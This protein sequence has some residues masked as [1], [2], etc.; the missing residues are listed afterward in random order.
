MRFLTDRSISCPSK[1]LRIRSKNA[2]NIALGAK[3]CVKTKTRGIGVSSYL[4]ARNCRFCIDPFRYS[5]KNYCH[6]RKKKNRKCW[7][8]VYKTQNTTTNT[9]LQYKYNLRLF[10]RLT[11]TNINKKRYCFII[12][13]Q[14]GL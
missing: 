6:S 4:Y 8:V 14:H 2:K 3:R 7:F 11:T 1:I 13:R 9:I 5:H 12:K 10:A